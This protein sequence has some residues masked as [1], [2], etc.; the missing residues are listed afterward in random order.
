M[1]HQ[2]LT[3]HVKQQNG[4]IERRVQTLKN[5]ERSMRAGAGVLD[6]YRFQAESLATSSS[7]TF[8]LHQRL[9]TILPTSY[10]S[11][12]NPHWIS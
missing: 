7:Q 4:V 1:I 6:D 3:P 10:F 8:N 5:M 11:T 9:M 12:S 2:P